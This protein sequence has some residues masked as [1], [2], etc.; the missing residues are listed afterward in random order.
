M[1]AQLISGVDNS[2]LLTHV[3][4][5]AALVFFVF[6]NGEKSG[7]RQICSLLVEDK[8]IKQSDLNKYFKKEKKK[9]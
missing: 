4:Y 6:R 7:A 5:V 8:V 2:L 3:A 1:E 9:K